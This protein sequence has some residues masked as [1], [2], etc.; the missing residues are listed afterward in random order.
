MDKFS[1]V[2]DNSDLVRENGSKAIINVD[3]E[4]YKQRVM[5]KQKSEMERKQKIEMKK[6]E[7]QI[8]KNSNDIKEVNEK[9]DLILQL[10]Q[11]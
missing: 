3:N 5:Q 8:S 11:K 1:D 6:M 7:N 9:L 2:K 4:A 10:L